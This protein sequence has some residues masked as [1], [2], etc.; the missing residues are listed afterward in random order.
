M[1]SLGVP[2]P[3]A[4][5]TLRL[6]QDIPPVPLLLVRV[7]WPDFSPPSV[8]WAAGDVTCSGASDWHL[9]AEPG[10]WKLILS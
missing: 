10:V 8:L 5:C 4:R 3:R 7:G 1:A 9:R 6:S 2:H